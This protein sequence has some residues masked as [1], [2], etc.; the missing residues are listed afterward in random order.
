MA[1]QKEKIIEFMYQGKRYIG[2]KYKMTSFAIC[3]LEIIFLS[4]AMTFFKAGLN[5][6]GIKKIEDV[7]L[8]DGSIPQR[9]A[10][11]VVFILALFAVSFLEKLMWRLFKGEDK[12]EV[13]KEN[14]ISNVKYAPM[15]MKQIKF[16]M[17]FSTIVVLLVS[18]VLLI[19]TNSDFMIGA[20]ESTLLISAIMIA[21][22]CGMARSRCEYFIPLGV[23]RGFIGVKE[24]F[25]LSEVH[26]T[27]FPDGGSGYYTMN[28]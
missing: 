3:L 8:F 4:Y 1:K 13:I 21:Q 7:G 2:K 22:F 17:A 28:V 20:I 10:Y 25:K 6:F 9:I 15:T 16:G 24:C 27:S 14:G 5:Y 19:F 12:I 23:D 26:L 11:M 18:I